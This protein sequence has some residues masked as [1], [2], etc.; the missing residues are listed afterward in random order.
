MRA[1]GPHSR[2]IRL[3]DNSIRVRDRSSRGVGRGSRPV[4]L[5]R[6]TVPVRDSPARNLRADLAISLAH[7]SIRAIADLG[8]RVRAVLRFRSRAADL[9]Q[10]A[11]GRVHRRVGHSADLVHS[12]PVDRRWDADLA[13]A[14]ARRQVDPRRVAGR[15]AVHSR[16]V[17]KPVADRAPVHRRLV[18]RRD[19]GQA[20]THSRAVPKPDAGPAAVHSGVVP[21]P[22][23]GPAAVHSRVVPKRDAGR[24]PVHRRL[25]PRRVAGPAAVHSRV[26]PQRDAGRAVAWVRNRV[27]DLASRAERPEVASPVGRATGVVER[28]RVALHAD[29][30]V[31]HPTACRGMRRRVRVVVRASRIRLGAVRRWPGCRRGCRAGIEPVDRTTRKRLATSGVPNSQDPMPRRPRCRFP[32]GIRRRDATV[33][34][35]TAR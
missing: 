9:R 18:L 4:G 33:R 32:D 11:E 29:P 7:N 22:D 8:R 35:M 15:A 10:D 19:A 21:K 30:V 1:R 13:E 2:A 25:V 26:V 16:A 31:D 20:A 3:V 17:P 5:D 27:A 34:R 14:R 23:A 6:G 12:K 28:G 24:A